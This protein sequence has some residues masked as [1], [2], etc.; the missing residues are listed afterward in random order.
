MSGIELTQSNF[1]KRTLLKEKSNLRKDIIIYSG[2][3]N[4]MKFVNVGYLYSSELNEEL[5]KVEQVTQ[6][7]EL[8]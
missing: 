1:I 4:P 5:E 6:G 3:L 7:R 8:P 2:I